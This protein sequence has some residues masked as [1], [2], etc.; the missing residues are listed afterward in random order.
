MSGIVYRTAAPEDHAWIVRVVDAWWERPVARA[1]PRLFLDH[2][3]RTSFVAE[4][5]GR[6]V[7]FLS[8]SSPEQACIHFVGVDPA[9][10]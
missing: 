5:E 4:E 1:I 8:P 3:H 2:F 6:P 9:V 7:G 10:R